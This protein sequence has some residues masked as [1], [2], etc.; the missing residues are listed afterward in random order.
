MSRWIPIPLEKLP[1]AGSRSLF[2]H[3]QNCVVLFNLDGHLYAIDNS[4]PHAGA[5]LFGGKLDGR[6]LQ[7][8]AH[9]LRFDISSGCM[10]HGKGLGVKRYEIEA[11]EDQF[12]IKFPDAGFQELSA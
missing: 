6:W 9:G 11:R 12:Y 8:P 7:C 3:E 10:A 4:C 1:E 5:S 2:W